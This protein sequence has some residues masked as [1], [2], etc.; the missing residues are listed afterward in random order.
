MQWLTTDW[1][2]PN[3]Q[4]AENVYERTC[5]DP[6]LGERHTADRSATLGKT[7]FKAVTFM[8]RADGQKE[9]AD[10]SAA[11]RFGSARATGGMT[12]SFKSDGPREKNQ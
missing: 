6:C 10:R 5:G 11:L 1:L 7:K 8:G 12:I 2:G 3:N 4:A 9:P